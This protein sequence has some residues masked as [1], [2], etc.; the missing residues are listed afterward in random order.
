LVPPVFLVFLG[1]DLFMDLLQ[2]ESKNGTLING[3]PLALNGINH[4]KVTFAHALSMMTYT[5]L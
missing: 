4:F 2:L 1:P 5:I 3:F